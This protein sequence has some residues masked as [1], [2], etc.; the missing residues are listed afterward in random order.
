MN[1][2]QISMIVLL[3]MGSGIALAKNGEPNTGKYSIIRT[4]IAQ[5]ILISILY[6]G[7]FWS[8]A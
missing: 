1:G 4:L 6:W 8:A 7:G 3:A 5:G 2:A